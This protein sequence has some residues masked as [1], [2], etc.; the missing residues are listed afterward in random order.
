V[1]LDDRH[2]SAKI[3]EVSVFER[4]LAATA[5]ASVASS[6]GILAI[7]EFNG[8]IKKRIDTIR[9][10]CKVET[11][12]SFRDLLITT[13]GLGPFISGGN[14][15][16]ETVKQSASQACV[17]GAPTRTLFHRAKLNSA[18]CLRRYQTEMKRVA[19]GGLIKVGCCS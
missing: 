10:D 7:D 4:E 5:A 15:Y 14:L 9:I 16:D 3:E 13:D 1:S 6:K 11:R 19:V 12:R 17:N 2:A 18:A 8:T